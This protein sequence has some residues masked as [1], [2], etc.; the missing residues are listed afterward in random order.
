MIRLSKENKKFLEEVQRQ[1]LQKQQQEQNLINHSTDW[2]ALE[3]FIQ[4]CNNNP[5]LVINVT[6]A[7]GTKLEIKTVKDERKVNPLF[8]QAAYEE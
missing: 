3:E 6:L 1:L 4:Q 7:D 8:T 5:G 2:G